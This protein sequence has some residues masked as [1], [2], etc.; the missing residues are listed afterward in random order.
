MVKFLL[1]HGA[2]VFATTLSDNETSIK[3]CE[4]DEEG[5]EACYEYL[6][7]AQKNLGDP[8]FN[9]GIAYALYSYDAEN[10]DELS[11][12]A[13]D[14]LIILDKYEDDFQPE[15]NDGWWNAKLVSQN[16]QGLVPNNYLG[17]F[18]RILK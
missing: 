3:K 15:E 12:K 13:G 4:E 16:K 5:Y 7:T 10:D 1:E 6:I 14:E 18:I 8:L 11:F 9:N 17:V 2:S